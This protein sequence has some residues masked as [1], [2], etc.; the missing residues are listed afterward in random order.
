MSAPQRVSLRQLLRAARDPRQLERLRFAHL[1]AGGRHTLEDLARLAGRSRSTI[2][3]WLQKFNAEGMSGL[4]E[5]D[6]SAGMVSPLAEKRIQSELRRGLRAGRWTSAAHIAEWL[7]KTHGVKRARKSVYYWL[8]KN[9]W[10]APATLP[11]S[12][13]DVSESARPLKASREQS[14]R[15]GR[16]KSKQTARP[17]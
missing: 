7:W 1:A 6:A 8:Q 15:A 13:A 3:N 12:A 9:G 5:R 16:S 17:V 4:L 10:P 14:P 2:Q 11:V